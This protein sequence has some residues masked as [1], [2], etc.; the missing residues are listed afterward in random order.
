MSG[1]GAK[2]L[3]GAQPKL[4]LDKWLW[5]A[6]FCKTRAEAAL[7]VEKGKVRING[8]RC[9]KPGH[10]IVAGDVLTFS[11]ADT[12][13]VIRVLGF[14]LRRG[15]ASEAAMLYHDVAAGA[16]AAATRLE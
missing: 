7:R 4:R 13:R 8:Q 11:H 14:G 12:V 3:P 16:D 10:G 5:Q 15:P 9:I 1:P 2:P 6:R